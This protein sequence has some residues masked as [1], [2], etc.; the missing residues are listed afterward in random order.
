MKQDE[1]TTN[2]KPRAVWF[3]RHQPTPEQI[4][5][6][7]GEFRVEYALDLGA[8]DLNSTDEVSAILQELRD[9]NPA[10]IFGVFPAP[11]LAGFARNPGVIRCYAAWNINRSKE[12]EKPSFEHKGFL[13]VASF[14]S[15]G[16]LRV[17]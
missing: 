6:M 5:E 10:A 13:K 7:E 3:S 15:K 12:G 8:R 14:A 16:Y 9:R 4:K 11:L 2:P 17:W 1:A